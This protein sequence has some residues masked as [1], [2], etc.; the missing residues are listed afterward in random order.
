MGV[1]EGWMSASLVKALLSL[2]LR[3]SL[4]LKG[5]GSTLLCGEVLTQ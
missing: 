4:A 3:F 1:F 2:I 5:P